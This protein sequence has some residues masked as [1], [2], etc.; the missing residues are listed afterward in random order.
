[1][2]RTS[3]RWRR[4]A[5]ATGLALAAAAIPAVAAATAASPVTYYACVTT[6]TGAVK[7]VS[8]TTTCGTGQH[9]ISWNNTGPAGPAGPPGPQGATG[10]QGPQGTT[11]PQGPPGVIDAYAH[12]SGT[13][14]P[15]S[16]SYWTTVGTLPLPA[17]SFLVTAQASPEIVG[18]ATSDSILCTLTDG[19]GN[20]L[21]STSYTLIE[22]SLTDGYGDIVLTGV[23]SAGGTMT[24]QCSDNNSQAYVT[25]AELTAIPAGM[26]INSGPMRPAP[27]LPQANPAG[28]ALPRPARA[29]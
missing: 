23:T 15:L 17:G 6:S 11:G 22:D 26:I 19:S 18:G 5:A 27:R 28:R 7:I 10:P 9:K 2:S 1:M 13:S 20:Y 24:L 21:D 29:R 12:G 3:T 4:A 16:Y 8:S 14:G 25:N